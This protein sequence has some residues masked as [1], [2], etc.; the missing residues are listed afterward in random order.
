MIAWRE[1]IGSDA[2]NNLDFSRSPG[3]AFALFISS[4]LPAYSQACECLWEGSFT[5]VAANADL[6]VLGSASPP[7]GNALDISVDVTLSGPDWIETP[8]VWLKTGEYCRPEVSEF[9]AGERYILALKKI[10]EIPD[11]GFNPSTPNVSFGRIGDYELSSC[12]GYWLTVKGLRASGN[13]VPGM[14]RYAHNPKMSPVHVGHVIAYLKGKA[15][16]ESLAEAARLDPELEALKK[17][18]RS[19]IRGFGDVDEDS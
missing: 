13:L 14:P 4:L 15:S 2:N 5:D 8:R 19:F 17:D 10:T 6:V 18:S 1:M 16:V 3:V 12:G 7:R 9:E 11:D